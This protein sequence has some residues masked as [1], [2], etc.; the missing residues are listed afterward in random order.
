MVK[1]G[2]FEI[3]RLTEIARAKWTHWFV[4]LQKLFPTSSFAHYR[5]FK[6]IYIICLIDKILDVKKTKFKKR[7]KYERYDFLV[8]RKQNSFT[9]DTSYSDFR[10]GDYTWPKTITYESKMGN[11][12]KA[13]AHSHLF[14]ST[15]S[16]SWLFNDADT[17]TNKKSA[18]IV[19]EANWRVKLNRI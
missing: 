3:L 6:L 16:P 10:F 5:I 17:N 18:K 12:F 1:I 8:L 2:L 13:I 15:A 19:C 11:N 9:P 4:V 14:L 7:E